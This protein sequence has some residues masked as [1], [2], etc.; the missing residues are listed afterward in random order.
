MRGIVRFEKPV[1]TIVVNLLDRPLT[2]FIVRDST[3]TGY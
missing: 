3:I 2:Y 1:N